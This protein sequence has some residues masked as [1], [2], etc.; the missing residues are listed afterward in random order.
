[1]NAFD[2]FV[3]IPYRDR[4]RDF[5][6]CDCYGLVWLVNRE[7][8]SRELPSLHDR[9]TL[10]ADRKVIA[11]LIAGEMQPWREVVAGAEMAF[12]CALMREGDQARHIGLIVAPGQLLHV[13]EDSISR[14][15]RY[16][17]GTM[18]HRI[19]GFF[20]YTVTT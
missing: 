20:R 7:I 15:E 17:S 6:G 16:R 8:L 14:I 11:G 1:M 12:D 10:P 13:E 18:R 9:Y 3:G 19:V 5:D 4:G 2:R